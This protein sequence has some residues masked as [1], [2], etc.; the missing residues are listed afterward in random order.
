MYDL[1]KE[2]QEAIA[3]GERALTSLK[4]A[5]TEL[6]KARRWGIFDM[7]G[8]DLLAGIMKYTKMDKAQKIMAAAQ[9][10]IQA[11]QRELQDIE[12]LGIN[13]EINSF[14]TIADFFC[15]GLIADWLVQSKINNTRK[16]IDEA[17]AKIE[18]ILQQ[19]KQ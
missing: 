18:A 10:D 3:A 17:I 7:L 11:F 13:I 15:D 2:K 16:N 4:N 19:L 8:G 14:L 1:Q 5:R 6:D 9:A 12:S